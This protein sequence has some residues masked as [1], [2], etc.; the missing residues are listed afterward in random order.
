MIDLK[1]LSVEQLLKQP[2]AKEYRDLE[3]KIKDGTAT[4]NDVT[5]KKELD[6]I[7]EQV[8]K[9]GSMGRSDELHKL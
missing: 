1:N 4:T 2:K 3:A 8:R 5:R 9:G 6:D 7:L